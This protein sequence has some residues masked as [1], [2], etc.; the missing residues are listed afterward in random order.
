M[1]E[2][3]GIDVVFPIGS[4]AWLPYLRNACRFVMQ[5]Q[6]PRQH[7]G[8]IIS[9]LY[10]QEE[11]L[12][13]LAELCRELEATLVMAQGDRD[14]FETPL[15]RNMG[16]RRTGRDAIAFI[17]C[18]VAIHP[19]TFQLASTVLDEKTGVILPVADMDGGPEDEIFTCA[20]PEVLEREAWWRGWRRRDALGAII[21]P[22]SA[23]F[24]VHGYDERMYG[25][26]ADDTD[27]VTR[28]QRHGVAMVALQEHGCPFAMHQ[29]HPTSR[30]GSALTDRNR[31]LLRDTTSIVRNDTTW[32][33]IPDSPGSDHST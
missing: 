16:A 14:A 27:F 20:D 23:V 9:Y 12:T 5:Q 8:I 24:A 33:G 17:D 4:M 22:R 11:P 21:V 30:R 32:G 1:N 13:E 7:I 26:G 29:K 6:Y 2:S 3:I 28:L 19:R 10:R 18:D 31:Q 25:W 15:A